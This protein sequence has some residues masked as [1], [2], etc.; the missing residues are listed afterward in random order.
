MEKETSR[1]CVATGEVKN[2]SELL[3]FVKTPD[4][5]LVPDFN[6]KLEGR[7]LYV[8]NSKT[9]LKHAL[10]KNL[11]IKSI[12]LF[13]KIPE[14]FLTQVEHLL[15]QR[16]LNALNLARKA[17][18]LVSG[19]EKVKTNIEKNK[20]AFIIEATDAALDSSRKIEA[21]SSNLETIKIYSSQDL[22]TAL[23][24]ENTIYLAILKSD[25][26][27]MVYENIKK[28]QTFLEN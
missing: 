10:E 19:F 20:V 24:K 16:G 14:D 15:Y 7:G 11:F 3:R 23:N 21:S 6:K 5:R 8:S 27:K 17:G 12:H 18:A 4:S 2:T 25:I 13:L 1:K 22:E 26:S 9:A 28:Y